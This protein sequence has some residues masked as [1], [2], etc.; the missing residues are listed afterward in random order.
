MNHRTMRLVLSCAMLSILTPAVAA[1]PDSQ[2]FTGRTAA[3]ASVE[4]R[5]RVSGYLT[6]VLFKDG[7]EVQE[8]QVLFQID[9]RPYQAD[10]DRARA[11]VVSAEAQL[12]VAET[13]YKRIQDLARKGVVSPEEIDKVAAE[14]PVARA[15]VASARAERTLAEFRLDSTRIRAPISG[16]IGQRLLDVG[17]LVRADR[18]SLARIIKDDPLYV[19]FDVDEITVLRLRRA[20]ADNDKGNSLDRLPVQ[21]GLAGE[22][23]FPHT[24]IVDFVSSTVN[25]QSGSLQVRALLPNTKHIFMPGMF[26]RVR[27]TQGRSP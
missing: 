7:S 9:A 19:Y 20:A 17:N 24:G 2:Q 14:I 21:I 10:L 26:A 27:I 15:G 11:A 5:S 12:K 23:G 22:R 25:A 4:L 3:S 1:P 8:G 6:N 18:T 16:H 13:G